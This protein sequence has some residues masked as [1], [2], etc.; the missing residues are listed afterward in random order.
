MFP[1][2]SFSVHNLACKNALFV[3]NNMFTYIHMEKDKHHLTFAKAY[4]E[5]NFASLAV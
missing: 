1:Q 3:R 2:K 5:S 4:Y